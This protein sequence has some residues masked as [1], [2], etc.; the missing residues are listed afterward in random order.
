MRLDGGGWPVM[1]LGGAVAAMWLR[2]QMYRIAMH[3][4]QMLEGDEWEYQRSI[5]TAY[6]VYDTGTVVIYE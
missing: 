5:S 4:W 6:D 3:W 1:Y 2:R